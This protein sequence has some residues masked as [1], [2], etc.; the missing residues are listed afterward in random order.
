MSISRKWLR[1]LSCSEECEARQMMDKT[2]CKSTNYVHFWFL[3]IFLFLLFTHDLTHE[4]IVYN[5]KYMT[6]K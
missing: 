6:E 3:H 5:N 2:V 4:F 1:Q